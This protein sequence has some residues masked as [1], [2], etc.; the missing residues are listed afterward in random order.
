MEGEGLWVVGD[1]HPLSPW[2]A[3]ECCG[4]E[5]GVQ[6]SVCLHAYYLWMETLGKSL[7][8]QGRWGGGE[9]LSGAAVGLR[10]LWVHKLVI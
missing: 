8:A 6:P 10:D 3:L 2:L 7:R 9:G 5:F 4:L 1:P